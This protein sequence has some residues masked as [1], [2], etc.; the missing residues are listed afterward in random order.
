MLAVPRTRKR[1]EQ[2]KHKKQQGTGKQD[3]HEL[4]VQNWEWGEGSPGTWG[5]SLTGKKKKSHLLRANQVYL[6]AVLPWKKKK[7]T[8][9]VGLYR[10]VFVLCEGMEP[11]SSTTS[12][13]GDQK[14]SQDLNRPAY[15][16]SAASS[17]SRVCTEFRMQNY[18]WAH[19]LWTELRNT[20]NISS[21]FHEIVPSLLKRGTNILSLKKN[22]KSVW[23]LA[24]ISK[25]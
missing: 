16:S 13:L 3:M 4:Q 24:L 5:Q 11:M 23:E 18:I 17:L 14:L 22:R 20:C 25:I 7:S 9:H 12:A 1:D 15:F 8:L 10:C 19:E 21:V 2:L 6:S